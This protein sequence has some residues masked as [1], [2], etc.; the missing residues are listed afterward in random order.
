MDTVLINGIEYTA[1]YKPLWHH[2]RGLI[3]TATGY[4]RKLTTPYMVNYAGRNR[5]LYCCQISNTG[6]CYMVIKGKWVVVS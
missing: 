6:T 3:Q 4:G 1:A 5:R 2:V